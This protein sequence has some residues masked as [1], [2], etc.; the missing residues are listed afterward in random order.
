MKIGFIGCGNMAKAIIGGIIQAKIF[1]NKNIFASDAREKELSEFCTQRNITASSNREI[2][3]K[4]DIILLAVKPQVF[5]DVLPEIAPLTDDSKLIISIA[6][7]K[8]ISFIE[9]FIGTHKIIRIMPNLNATIQQSVSAVCG[10]ALCTQ[11][12]MT[13]AKQIFSSIGSVYELEEDK[14]YIFSAVACCSPAFTFMY[15]DALAKAGIAYGLDEKT[16]FCAAAES[17]I[18]S[19]QMLKVSP[20]TPQ[21]LIDKVCSPGGTTIEGVNV[22]RSENLEHTIQKAVKAS[23]LRDKQL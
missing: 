8:T 2:A 5:P 10:N 22:L 7:G 4:C 17:V 19:A 15:I 6:A 11:N 12:D 14:F 21:V 9:S 16:A 3:T 18:G 13:I 23:Y 20:E 1:E